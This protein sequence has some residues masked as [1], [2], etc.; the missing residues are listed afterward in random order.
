MLREEGLAPALRLVAE[1]SPLPVRLTTSTTTT[2]TGS[3]GPGDPIDPGRLHPDTEAALYFCGLEALQNAVKHAAASRIQVRLATVGD[4]IELLV[5]DD[6]QGFD[7][8]TVLAAGGL[9]NLR[10]RVDSMDGDLTVRTNQAGGTD[11]VVRVRIGRVTASARATAESGPL[12]TL[13]VR[14]DQ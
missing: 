5:S 8:P 4:R 9:G 1:S 3:A 6:G 13:V 12:P 7:V 10:D 11:V 14:A 2:T